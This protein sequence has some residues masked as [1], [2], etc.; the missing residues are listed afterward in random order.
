M[1]RYLAALEV[2]I[3]LELSPPR[4]DGSTL[5][6]PLSLRK[7][8]GGEGAVLGFSATDNAAHARPQSVETIFIGGGTP[9]HLNPA[10]LERLLGLISEGFKLSVA[11]EYSIEANPATLDADRVRV[12]KDFGVNRVSLG[13]QSFNPAALRVLERDHGEKQI[14]QATD[15]IRKHGQDLS[16]DL[17]FGV[18]GQTPQQWRDDLRQALE[19]VPDHISAYGLTYEKGTRLWKQRQRGEVRPLGEDMEAQMYRDA[20]EI[21]SGAG[22][23]QYEI[24]NY[25]RPCKRCRHNE[26]Y[27]ANE[28]YFGVGLGA[29]SYVEGRRQTNTRNVEQYLQRLLD[30]RRRPTQHSEKLDD[31]ERARETMAI[32]LRRA[33]GINRERF[34]LQTGF[35]IDRVM[36]PRASHYIQMKLVHDD[37]IS[38][39]LTVAGRLV[40]DSIIE[41][42]L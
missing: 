5:P 27:W 14:K 15:L 18:P 41:G 10:R 13:A 26:V 32:Q 20:L 35:E 7:T 23:E 2:E 9:T 30:D 21:L 12:L 39:C 24:S 16:L 28:A 29:A 22:Y 38:V 4:F 34:L 6:T 17:I 3:S 40:A 1:D 8:G 37:G 31:G 36:G 11:G 33:E 19:L 42:I 25:A